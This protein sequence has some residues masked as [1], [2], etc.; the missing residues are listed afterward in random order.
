MVNTTPYYANP[1]NTTSVQ[2]FFLV[3]MSNQTGGLWGYLLLAGIFMVFF[4]PLQRY[5]TDEAFAAS[6][7]ITMIAAIMLA[8]FQIIGSWVLILLVST[9]VLSVVFLRR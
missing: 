9:T 6:S 2:D 7:F 5:S 4:L 8:P 3:Y 1:T